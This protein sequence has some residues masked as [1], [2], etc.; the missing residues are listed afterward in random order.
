MKLGQTVQEVAESMP[1]GKLHQSDMRHLMGR[2]DPFGLPD[3]K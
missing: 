1:E 3:F 2:D